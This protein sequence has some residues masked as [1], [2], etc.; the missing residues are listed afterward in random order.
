MATLSQTENRLDPFPE[1]RYSVVIIFLLFIYYNF[2]GASEYHDLTDK[3]KVINSVFFVKSHFSGLL[4]SSEVERET[5]LN[6]PSVYRL[7]FYS[8]IN[9]NG[10]KN[11]AIAFFYA[12]VPGFFV[13]GLGH[14]YIGDMRTF[15]ILLITEAISLPIIYY[16]AIASTADQFEEGKDIPLAD[17][18]LILSISAFLI[19]WIYDFVA[20]PIKAEYVLIDPMVEDSLA[21]IPNDNKYGEFS[22]NVFISF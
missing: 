20:A 6:S 13:H 16:S 14:H 8:N 7:S 21:R 9:P 18:V 10:E 4:A 2:S 22:L 1:F 3:K 19:S 11:A 17:G 12:F 15:K 5:F